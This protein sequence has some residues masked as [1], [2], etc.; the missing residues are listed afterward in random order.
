MPKFMTYQRPM[1]VSKSGWTG[2]PGTP[3]GKPG[4]RAPKPAPEPRQPQL[5]LEL[6]LPCL[7]KS[8]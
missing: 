6:K 8:R 2:R 5:E 3:F 4:K 1:P 7:P